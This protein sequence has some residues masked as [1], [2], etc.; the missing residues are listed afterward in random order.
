MNVTSMETVVREVQV[1]MLV[2]LGTNSDDRHC[3]LSQAM[4]DCQDA[5]HL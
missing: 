4:D 5:C 2:P 3:R 1:A